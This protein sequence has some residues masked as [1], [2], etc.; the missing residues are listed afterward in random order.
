MRDIFACPSFS[1]GTLANFDADCSRRLEP[2]EAAIRELATQSDVAG[3][4]ETGVRATGSLHWLHTV[5]TPFLT[6]Y[7]AH[8]R[9]GREAMDAAG[10]L[11]GY[12]CL[13]PG[14]GYWAILCILPQRVPQAHELKLGVSLPEQLV[15]W[16]RIVITSEISSNLRDHSHRFTQ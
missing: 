3:F 2:V 13:L 16:R 4:D 5:S 8:K 1:E 7:Y 15:A 6:W 11:P 14:C 10:I 9:R 12:R